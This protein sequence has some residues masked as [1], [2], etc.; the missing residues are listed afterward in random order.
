MDEEE[1]SLVIP[2]VLFTPTNKME[3]LLEVAL[4]DNSG[5]SFHEWGEIAKVSKEHI[6]RWFQ[7]PEFVSW[8]TREFEKRLDG[9]KLI[10]LKI[11]LTKMQHDYKHWAD[12]GK[13]FYPVG[14]KF[15]KGSKEQLG[16]LEEEIITI[17]KQKRVD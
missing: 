5:V 13:I 12:L 8:I 9:Y 10:W 16:R 2:E 14:V 4:R 3:H 15:S 6:T 11:G 7:D 1:N 17:L